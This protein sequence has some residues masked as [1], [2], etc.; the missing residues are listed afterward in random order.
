MVNNEKERRIE[1]KIGDDILW[2]SV[3]QM[4]QL[5]NCILSERDSDSHSLLQMF[6]SVNAKA[7]NESRIREAERI[8]GHENEIIRRSD[9]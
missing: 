5:F 6:L 8:K 4:Q 2:L 9:D 1:F 3:L 7:D